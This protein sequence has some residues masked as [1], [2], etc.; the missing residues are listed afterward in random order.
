MTRSRQRDELDRDAQQPGGPHVLIAY[1]TR[2]GSTTGIAERIAAALRGAGTRV[3]LRRADMV[4]SVSEYDAVVFGSP[5]YDQR[6]L[7]AGDRFVRR[8]LAVLAQ[9]PTWLF[10]VGSFSDRKRIIGPLVRR[11]PKDIGAL[12]DTI[13]PRG[14]RVF[15]G[16][17]D[18]SGRP[19]NARLLYRALGG[20]FG[21]NRDWH[22][23]EDWA[24][25]IAAT[26]HAL[27]SSR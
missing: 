16:I 5:V 10:S 26:V 18:P 4:D 3:T 12:Q 14:Y 23:I 2:Y 17:I 22:D 15:A 25:G 11:E 7:P 6:W 20:R 1:A 27:T 8:H 24:H 21:D 19:Q 13:G 9:R